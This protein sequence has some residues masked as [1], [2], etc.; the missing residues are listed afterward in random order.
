M[1]SLIYMLPVRAVILLIDGFSLEG[2]IGI[3]TIPFL[4]CLIKSKEIRIENV[5]E[6]KLR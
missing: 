1:G 6:M 3:T 4:Y 5:L 2:N